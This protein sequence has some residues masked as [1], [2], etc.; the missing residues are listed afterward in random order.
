MAETQDKTWAVSIA[1]TR[2]LVGRRAMSRPLSLVGDGITSLGALPWRAA[3]HFFPMHDM[4]SARRCLGRRTKSTSLFA[5]VC[6]WSPPAP[7]SGEDSVI[8]PSL[9]GLSLSDSG[10]RSKLMQCLASF[11]FLFCSFF[12]PSS[13]M[14]RA[15]ALAAREAK[16]AAAF[17]TLVSHLCP[18]AKWGDVDD[19][20]ALGSRL[21]NS[22]ILCVEN[23]VGCRGRVL[24][25]RKHAT[26]SLP[27]PWCEFFPC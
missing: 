24:Y 26:P 22:T 20:T 25:D 3:S 12:F 14:Y 7:V 23:G 6:I 4:P 27:S 10:T 11:F 17:E 9:Y 2:A 13:V 15:H 19:G 16:L 21:T 1:A 5:I 8:G 18:L